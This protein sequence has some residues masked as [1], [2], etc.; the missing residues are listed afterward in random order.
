MAASLTE[1]EGP[2]DWYRV[3]SSNACPPVASSQRASLCPPPG[4]ILWSL[5]MIAICQDWCLG[6]QSRSQRQE[7]NQRSDQGRHEGEKQEQVEKA[8]TRAQAMKA[9]FD[10]PASQD[11]TELHGAL[12]LPVLQSLVELSGGGP[13]SV[14]PGS[15][16]HQG[17][18]SS[19]HCHL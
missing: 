2:T 16:H 10:V 18:K 9:G 15:S 13:D 12:G 11:F 8:G 6:S 5:T 7:A 4:H 17:F 19:R 14:T 3:G 1:P